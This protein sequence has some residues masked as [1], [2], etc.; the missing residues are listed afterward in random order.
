MK[1]I[2][3]YLRSVNLYSQEKVAKSIGVSRQSYNKYEAG[4]VIPS[5]KIVNKLAELYNITPEFIYNNQVPQIPG[6][7]IGN[8]SVASTAPEYCVKTLV[9]PKEIDSPQKQIVP[10]AQTYRAVYRHGQIIIEDSELNFAEG[11]N[12]LITIR[13]ETEQE[14]YIRKQKSWQVIENF[15][16]TQNFT[17]DESDP[18][19]EKLRREA[20]NA[21]Y[22]PF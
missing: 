7:D 6:K 13:E 16:S 4:T 9:K 12:I 11:Q 17:T 8:L 22:G 21:K 15:I 14:E 2:L 10:P 18:F 20:I 3:K 5:N 19:Y 1:E